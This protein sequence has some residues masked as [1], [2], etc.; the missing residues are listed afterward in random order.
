MRGHSTVY[1][2][3]NGERTEHASTNE[4]LFEQISS[5]EC[6]RA[7]GAEGQEDLAGEA[8]F[9]TALVD[10]GP[11]VRPGLQT[12][13]MSTSDL[14]KDPRKTQ[15]MT[16]LLWSQAMLDCMPWFCIWRLSL[17]TYGGPGEAAV[18]SADLSRRFGT[19]L[20]HAISQSVPM[21]TSNLSED[22]NAITS[23]G[24]LRVASQATADCL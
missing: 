5:P 17:W 10:E 7:S 13:V 8:F 9:F 15:A 6:V 18:D 2:V 21:I 14:S 4:G 3:L 19:L 11:P 16:P 23:N 22:A 20:P 12:E 1:D 24:R